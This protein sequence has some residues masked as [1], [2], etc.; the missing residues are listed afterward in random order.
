MDL[1]RRGCTGRTGVDFVAARRGLGPWDVRAIEVNLRK[2]GTTHPYTALRNLVPGHYDTVAGVWR[3]D[4]GG[5]RAYR[6]TDYVGGPAWTGR[7]PASVIAAVND[8]GLRFDL[9]QG[10]GL[11]LH[12]LA[13]LA[14]DGHFGA[15]A[16]GRTPGHAEEL[17]D[18]LLVAVT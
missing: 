12:M 11:V 4:A 7:S 8:A 13:C 16:I 10:T 6:S 3:A 9:E 2:G 1:T 14:V 17:F 15:T 18:A 5:T